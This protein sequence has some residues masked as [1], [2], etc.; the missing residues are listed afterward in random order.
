MND[1]VLALLG[2]A[3]RARKVITGE[4]TVVNAIRSG[5]VYL[6][7]LASDTLTNTTKKIKDKSKFYNVEVIDRYNT[8]EL[9]KYLG[10]TRKVIGITDKGF[11]KSMLEKD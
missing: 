7:L 11:A 2:M 5:K 3:I 10:K 4:E 8:L 6:V 9:A 1:K